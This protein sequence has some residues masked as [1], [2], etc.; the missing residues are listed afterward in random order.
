MKNITKVLAGVIAAVT[1][2]LQV[3]AIQAALA[4]VLTAHPSISAAIAGVAAILA[5]LHAPDA[6]APKP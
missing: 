2:L 5:L 4:S 3:P 6:P 1:A